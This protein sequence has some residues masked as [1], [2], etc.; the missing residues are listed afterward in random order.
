MPA[1]TSTRVLATTSTRDAQSS[2]PATWPSSMRHQATIESS[3]AGTN[4]GD[5]DG[6]NVGR[7]GHRISS[8]ARRY[9]VT[10][11]TASSETVATR[12][13]RH[14]A[15]DGATFIQHA[16]TSAT[17]AEDAAASDHLDQTNAGSGNYVPNHTSTIPKL[18]M[19]SIAA[20]HGPNSDRAR[21]GYVANSERARLNSAAPIM[22][23]RLG[24]AAA[25]PQQRQRLQQ[26]STFLL[27]R[28][29]PPLCPALLCGAHAVSH[30][31]TTMATMNDGRWTLLVM[32]CGG[33]D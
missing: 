24:L 11:G 22:I 16:A 31:W 20:M 17:S 25:I 7:K 30:Q 26:P 10:S 14:T 27:H 18:R 1:T 29:V 15:H 3:Q 8:T 9:A 32:H 12:H 5:V 33:H 19:S 21:Q 6:D 13:R 28:C 23:P 2:L 4:C